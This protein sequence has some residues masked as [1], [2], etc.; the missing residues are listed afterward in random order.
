MKASVLGLYFYCL[1][2]SKTVVEFGK[3][4]TVLRLNGIFMA[5]KEGEYFLGVLA[6]QVYQALELASLGSEFFLGF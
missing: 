3:T 1:E 4:L 5:G 6:L 2:L